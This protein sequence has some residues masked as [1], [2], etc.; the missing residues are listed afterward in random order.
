MEPGG[1]M[2]H[3]QGLSNKL[4]YTYVCIYIYIYERKTWKGKMIKHVLKRRKESDS[5]LATG[6][7]NR[8][9]AQMTMENN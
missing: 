9:S 8:W 5:Y 6:S 1:S 2:P 3:S 7:R 4:S